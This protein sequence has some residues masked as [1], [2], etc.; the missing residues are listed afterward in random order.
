MTVGDVVILNTTAVSLGLGTGGVHFVV[1]VEGAQVGD[2]DAP[3]RVMK[4]RYT[5]SQTAVS[6]VEETHREAHRGFG[7][8]WSRHRSSALR[9]TRCSDRSPP[10]PNERAMRASCTS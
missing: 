5:P 4:A 2:D 9:C 6:S 1:A 7:A 10:V 8:G 3:G